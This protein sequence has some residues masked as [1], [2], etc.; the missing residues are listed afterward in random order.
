M[1]GDSG[2]RRFCS[3]V[4]RVSYITDMDGDGQSSLA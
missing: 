2:S 4:L 3:E 1:S